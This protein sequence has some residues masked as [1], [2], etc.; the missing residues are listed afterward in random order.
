VTGAE[1]R[2]RI[3]CLGLTY[4]AAARRLGLSSAGLHHNMRDERPIGRRTKIILG[5]LER[6][7]LGQATSQPTKPRR[8]ATSAP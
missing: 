5:Y 6:E 8:P 4:T 3:K 1:L 2:Q 7:A